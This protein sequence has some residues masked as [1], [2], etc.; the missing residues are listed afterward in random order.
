MREGGL[1]DKICSPIVTPHCPM[2][3]PTHAIFHVLLFRMWHFSVL[4]TGIPTKVKRRNLKNSELVETVQCTKILIIIC[5]SG[6]F[7]LG[8]GKHPSPLGKKK[9]KKKKLK[10]N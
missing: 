7:H 9:K 1:C 2:K 4:L 10:K 6:F 5:S 3:I 8:A